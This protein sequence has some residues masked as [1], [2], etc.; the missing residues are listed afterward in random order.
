MLQSLINPIMILG[1]N[2]NIVIQ[3]LLLFL[4]PRAQIHAD[5]YIKDEIRREFISLCINDLFSSLLT[6]PSIFMLSE[7]FISDDLI[8]YSRSLIKMLSRNK[9]TGI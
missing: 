1:C 3:T 8:F 2:M 9:P 6:A 7:N 5:F 4:N